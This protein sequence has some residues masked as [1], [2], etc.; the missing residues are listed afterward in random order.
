MSEQYNCGNYYSNGLDCKSPNE[1]C[2]KYN[3]YM[4]LYTGPMGEDGPEGPPGGD[5]G[6]IGPIGD[7]GPIGDTGNTGATGNDGTIPGAQTYVVIDSPKGV[8]PYLNTIPQAINSS[9]GDLYWFL[10]GSW[11]HVSNVFGGPGPDGS[12]G[13][14]GS[15]SSTERSVVRLE[16]DYNIHTNSLVPVP[17]TGDNLIERKLEGPYAVKLDYSLSYNNPNLV[18]GYFYIQ[19]VDDG[20]VISQER[21][22]INGTNNGNVRNTLKYYNSSMYQGRFGIRWY[23]SHS[24]IVISIDADSD[25]IQLKLLY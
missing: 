24:D 11:Q 3:S 1:I 18:L 9:N 19:I 20:S 2:E 10:R 22:N 14:P 13:P 23:V 6:D 21:V 16:H 5:D 25:Y 15:Q 8:P 12:R 17:V 7:V 4:T